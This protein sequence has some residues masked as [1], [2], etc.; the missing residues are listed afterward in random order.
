MPGF[1]GPEACGARE[2]GLGRRPQALKGPP[3]A[4]VTRGNA[5]LSSVFRL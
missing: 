1:D 5:V 3:R 4:D 2:N